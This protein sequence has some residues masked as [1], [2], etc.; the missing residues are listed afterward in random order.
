MRRMGNNINQI[1][2][3]SNINQPTDSEQLH[4]VLQEQVKTPQL[5]NPFF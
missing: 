2:H 1:A 4:Q 5:L 3:A